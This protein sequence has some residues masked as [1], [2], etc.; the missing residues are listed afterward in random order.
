M[1]APILAAAM[2]VLI[3]GTAVAA[4]GRASKA[5]R[6]EFKR[7]I[8]K[9]ETDLATENVVGGTV[10]VLG[11]S[12]VDL[13]DHYG[14]ADKAQGVPV[15]YNT[16]FHWASVT[17]VF[18]AIAAMQLV[19][20]GQIALDD[21]VIK[22]IPEFR[23][24]HSEYGRV[25]DV[26]IEHLLTHS[27]GLR[28]ASWPFNADGL[29]DRASWQLHEPRDW[30]Q[31]AALFPYTA[32]E[33]KPGTQASYSNLGVLIL[34][35]VVSRVSNEDIEIQIE[36][37]ILRPLGMHESYF[38]AT[39]LRWEARRTH[40]YIVDKEA[41]TDQ[42]NILDTGATAANGGLNAT[43]DDMV[44]FVRF[45]MGS[46]DAYPI[47]KRETLQSMLVPRL[48]FQKDDRRVVSVGLGFFISD[49]KDQYG[50]TRRYFGHSGFQRG[51]RSNLLIADDGSFAFIFAANS[52]KKGG[53]P[54]PS[55]LR[56]DLI[57]RL[58]PLMRKA[59]LK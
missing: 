21:P 37:N 59:Q 1:K 43:V 47:L 44:R 58:F 11:G 3:P 36:K 19:E 16:Q 7:A 20:R 35:E 22:Y 54:S 28:G 18:T 2:L 4:D 30:H 13:R 39:P 26:T 49:E 50:E 34:G 8:D 15:N 42:G 41:T 53:N 14:Y 29:P 57:D 48:V 12:G 52:V 45:L 31:I 23:A 46:S 55:K 38:D 32:L 51:N 17:K 27:S 24:V 40:D 33:F 5:E 56:I 9:Y 10:V 6:A 25:E